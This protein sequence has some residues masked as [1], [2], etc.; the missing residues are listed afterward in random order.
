[1]DT[2][3]KRILVVDDELDILETLEELLDNFKVD[4]ASNF[5]DALKYLKNNKYDVAV[6]DIMGVRGYDLLKVT[7]KLGTPSLMLTAHALSPSNLKESIKLGADAY[8]PKDKLLDIPLYIEDVLTAKQNKI[9]AGT[10]WF[11]RLAPFF[12]K[13]FGKKWQEPEKDF[14]DDFNK[15]A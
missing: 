14:W 6:L 15:K 9:K 10:D 11:A 2:I 1:M 4:T 12:T 3:K 5:E 13:F 7:T 8:I